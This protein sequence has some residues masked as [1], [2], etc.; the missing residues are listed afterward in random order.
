MTLQTV[1]QPCRSDLRPAESR[2]IA[3]PG[4][5]IRKTQGSVIAASH[6]ASQVQLPR[7]RAVG[8]CEMRFA[9]K[10]GFSAIWSNPLSAESV[11]AG[12]SL[13]VA[14]QRYSGGWARRRPFDRT[15]SRSW[16][17]A[18]REFSPPKPQTFAPPSIAYWLE[19]C[20]LAPPFRSTTLNFSGDFPRCTAP[21][22]GLCPCD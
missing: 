13:S 15:V 5:E 9:K 14:L 18:L 1:R 16:C 7:N 17:Y 20:R 3:L 2:S 19:T 12:E 4:P 21:C 11:Q 22:P 8:A 10:T 6:C